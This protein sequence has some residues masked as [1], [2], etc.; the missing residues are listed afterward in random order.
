MDFQ[1]LRNLFSDKKGFTLVELMIVVAIIGILAAIAIPS[2]MRY[3]KSSKTAEA[4]NIMRKMADGATSY[5]TSQQVQ[6]GGVT[7]C[8]EPWHSGGTQGMPVQFEDKVFPGGNSSVQLKTVDTVPVGGSKYTP[9]S[10]SGGS[11][12]EQAAKKLNLALGDPLYFQYKY[13]NSGTG[14][15]AS[16]SIEAV[17]DFETGS[18]EAHTVT[19]TIN[20]TDGEVQRGGAVTS[21][22][23][24]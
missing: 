11:N 6:C 2:F 1:N 5:F 9:S 8:S 22:E 19:Q 4:E 14:N 17:H 3:M 12:V 15:D 23:Y 7:N 20:V 16:A 18:D 24:E 21:N 10:F 13:N